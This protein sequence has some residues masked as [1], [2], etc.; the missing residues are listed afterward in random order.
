MSGDTALWRPAALGQERHFNYQAAHPQSTAFNVPVG[1]LL[2]GSSDTGAIIDA[3]RDLVWRHDPM[4]SRHGR[5][6]GLVHVLPESPEAVP[7][8]VDDLRD[9]DPLT[10]TIELARLGTADAGSAFDLTH[11]VASRMRVVRLTDSE[12]AVIVVIHHIAFDGWSSAVL[13]RELAR[14]YEA[15]R[16]GDTDRRPPPAA[17]YADYAIEQRRR[18]ERGEFA[19]DVAWWMSELTPVAPALDWGAVTGGAGA[20]VPWWVAENSWAELPSELLAAVQTRARELGVTLYAWLAAI[21]T[22]AL[23]DV[24]GVGQ[25]AVGMPYAARDDRRW[26]DLVGFFVNTVVLQSTTAS[27]ATVAEAVRST[28]QQIRDAHAHAGAPFGLVVDAVQPAPAPGVTPLFQT[29]LLL[30]NTAPPDAQFA[31]LQLRTNRIVN[32]G[33]R[34]D[35]MFSIG[36]RDGRPGLELETRS[37]RVSQEQA[38]DLAQRFLGLL[39][40]SV[41]DPGHRIVDLAIVPAEIVTHGRGDREPGV[42]GLFS[43]VV[44]DW[45]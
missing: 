34:Y 32:G 12:L 11:D 18:A 38:W 45:R 31:D 19:A 14:C 40:A 9:A 25:V 17:I 33:A 15:V 20:E 4:R 30:Q 13:F 36:W 24:Y 7:V 43:A 41:Q 42:D 5:E 29:M 8:V 28:H 21:Y 22:T 23:Q 44:G 3:F 1:A 10:R 39:A 26:H 37:C 16:R 6:T 2:R 35:L 27:T